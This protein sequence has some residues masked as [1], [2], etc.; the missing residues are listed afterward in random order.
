MGKDVVVMKDTTY[1]PKIEAISNI[2]TDG[3]IKLGN[4]I[5]GATA[6]LICSMSFSYIK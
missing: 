1:T 4:W 3:N 5:Y 6:T 2:G